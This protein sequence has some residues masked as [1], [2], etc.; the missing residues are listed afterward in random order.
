MFG[1]LLEFFAFIVENFPKLR[2]IVEGP[3]V[4]SAL[5]PSD[6]ECPRD[7]SQC[8]NEGVPKRRD[9]LSFGRRG[10]PSTSSSPRYG[11][12]HAGMWCLKVKGI[13]TRIPLLGQPQ[14][15]E[16]IRSQPYPHH[17]P[18]TE[19]TA[20]RTDTH[21]AVNL[22]PMRERLPVESCHAYQATHWSV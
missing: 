19:A 21:G 18:H 5:L 22:E 9:D 4:Y 6:T 17:H 12:F 8:G 16:E 11:G 2:L 7:R 13:G 14:L 1:A 20:A 3:A 10:K 15:K